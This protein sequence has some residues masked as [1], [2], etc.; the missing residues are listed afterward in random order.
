MYARK[1]LKA[2]GSQRRIAEIRLMFDSIREESNTL[3]SPEEYNDKL[4]REILDKSVNDLEDITVAPEDRDNMKILSP[5]NMNFVL[6][7]LVDIGLLESITGRNAIKRELHRYPGR[8][9]PGSKDTFAERFH[10]RPSAYKK[11]S[12]VNKLQKFISNPQARKFVYTTLRNSGIL[13]NY[14]KFCLASFFIALKRNKKIDV[15]KSDSIAQNMLKATGGNVIAESKIKSMQNQLMKLSEEQIKQ[16]LLSEQKHRWKH[17]KMMRIFCWAYLEC[18]NRLEIIIHETLN[19]LPIDGFN[20]PESIRIGLI[21]QIPLASLP[22]SESVYLF[23]AAA[24]RYLHLVFLTADNQEMSS[25]VQF[26]E[27]KQ[28]FPQLYV[29]SKSMNYV[30]S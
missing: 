27:I 13:Y 24:P 18:D 23:L 9:N 10:G 3:L 12:R 29:G 4:T 26:F 30:Q 15:S 19:Y 11:S 21:V 16:F 6:E 7:T 2:A 8:S 22:K 17:E 28:P 5:S 25:K 1:L 20:C 14:E